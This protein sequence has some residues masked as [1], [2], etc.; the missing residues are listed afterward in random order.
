[1]S[2]RMPI[3]ILLSHF[4]WDWLQF[5]V[6]DRLGRLDSQVVFT[7]DYNE[8]WYATPWAERSIL[9]DDH[10]FWLKHNIYA[11]KNF[12]KKRSEKEAERTIINTIIC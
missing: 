5:K 3:S 4:L 10:S 12:Q 8:H 6:S 9:G 1:M 11:R 2:V 7:L